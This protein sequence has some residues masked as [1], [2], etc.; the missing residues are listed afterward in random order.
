MRWFRQ[1]VELLRELH[2]LEAALKA[3]VV[4]GARMRDG[5]RTIGTT[6]TT[7]WYGYGC[8]KDASRTRTSR[9]GATR[10]CDA[11]IAADALGLPI[12]YKPKPTFGREAVGE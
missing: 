7:V 12:A 6:C 4:E 11:C 2:H 10:W 1:R 3:H 8:R 9:Y 5:L